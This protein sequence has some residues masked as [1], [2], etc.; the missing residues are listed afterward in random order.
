M[1]AQPQLAA[2]QLP[3]E[4]SFYS[5]S[6]ASRW[7]I[8][9]HTV[10]YA[11]PPRVF[12]AL[13]LPEYREAWIS[14]PEKDGNWRVAVSH[15]HPRYRIDLQSAAGD[16]CISGAYLIAQPHEVVFTWRKGDFTEASETLVQIRLQNSAG[17][18]NVRLCHRGFTSKTEGLWH[19]RFWSVSLGK[20]A[21]LLERRVA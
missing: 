7:D 21:R 6:G 5:Q 16:M 18:S 15:D 4:I 14:P 1:S 9:I 19:Q 17:R 2:P 11:E 20:L 12:H 8:A 13:T 10:F 3:Q